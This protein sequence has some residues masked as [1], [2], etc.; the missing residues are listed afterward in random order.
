MT[1]P[2][3]S[4]IFDFLNKSN[5]IDL[6][7]ILINHKSRNDDAFNATYK[8]LII[9]RIRMQKNQAGDGQHGPTYAERHVVGGRVERDEHRAGPGGRVALPRLPGAALHRGRARLG[10]DRVCAPARR[11]P[12]DV[13]ALRRLLGAAARR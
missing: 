4:I 10:L 3:K 9:K 12:P 8:T 1:Y 6:E 13:R 11:A 5:E 2:D 7:R